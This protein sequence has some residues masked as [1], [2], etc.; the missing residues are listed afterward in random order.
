MDFQVHYAPLSDDE[1]LMIAASRADLVPIP[2]PDRV[3]G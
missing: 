1:L 3:R 2:C